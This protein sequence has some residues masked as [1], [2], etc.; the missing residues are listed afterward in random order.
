MNMKFNN[1]IKT[2]FCAGLLA[3]STTS[4]ADWLEVKME[5]QI[6]D[7]MLYSEESGFK[8]ALNGVYLDMI[9]LYGSDLSAGKIDIMAQYYNVTENY[10]HAYKI[11]SGY[12]LDDDSFEYFLDNVWSKAYNLIAN[13]NVLLEHCDAENATLPL[14][15]GIKPSPEGAAGPFPISR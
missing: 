7:N 5:D 11:Y 6:M 1:K 15:I 8:I 13:N 4:C 12:K 9:G 10:D 3:A 14:R 2:F